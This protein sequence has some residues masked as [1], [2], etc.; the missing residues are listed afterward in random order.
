MSQ[1][2]IYR[3]GN[4][5][6]D[7]LSASMKNLA[8]PY[9]FGNTSAWPQMIQEA[10]TEDIKVIWTDYTAESHVKAL[11][12]NI[13]VKNAYDFVKQ[14]SSV[15]EFAMSLLPLAEKYQA[16]ICSTHL[17]DHLRIC[18]QKHFQAQ[19][20]E[21][22]KIDV[23]F[24]EEMGFCEPSPETKLKLE[25]RTRQLKECRV[26]VEAEF[27]EKIRS[28]IPSA[29]I[30]EDEVDWQEAGVLFADHHLTIP[31]VSAKEVIRVCSCCYGRKLNRI[32]SMLN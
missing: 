25:K 23:P 26:K 9:N 22:E 32:P 11:A 31:E 14:E 27:T 19:A 17:F 15:E 8:L 18:Q 30:S 1:I 21:V 12:G 13:E 20:E 3:E 7:E 29:I 6:M 5:F 4:A 2:A 10:L 28:I 16:V 24:D